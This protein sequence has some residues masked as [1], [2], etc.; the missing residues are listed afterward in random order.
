MVKGVGLFVGEQ[1]E[2]LFVA[3]SGQLFS[4]LA[5]QFCGPLIQFI[6]IC[7]MESLCGV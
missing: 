2:A 4:C 3:S 6:G 7:R 5:V 1:E